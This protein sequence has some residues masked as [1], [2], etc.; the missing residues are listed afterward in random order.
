[1][2]AECRKVITELLTLHESIKTDMVLH[3]VKSLVC[4]PSIHTLSFVGV[5]VD[6]PGSGVRPV[7]RVLGGSFVGH[8]IIPEG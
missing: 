3:V 5:V 2:N 7:H 4:L 8:P 6:G 1:M